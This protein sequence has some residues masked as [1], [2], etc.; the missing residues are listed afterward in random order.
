MEIDT[1]YLKPGMVLVDDVNGK[2]GKP[3]VPKNTTLTDVEIE[4][5]QKFL[6]DKVNILHF[7]EDRKEM[8]QKETSPPERKKHYDMVAKSPEESDPF[9]NVFNEVVGQFKSL[10]NAWKANIPVNM[11]HVR[12]LCLPLF[13][14]V[15]E[16][17]LTDVKSIL[18]G[19]DEDLF[20]YKCVAVSLLSIKLAQQLRYEKKDWLQIGFAAILIDIGLTKSKPVV[21]SEHA[22]PRHPI[23]SYEMIKD[24]PTLTKHTKI[25][26]V[27]HHEHLDGSGFPMKLTEGKIHPFARIIAVAD[28]YFTLFIEE[29]E[30]INTI[31]LSATDKYDEKIVRLLIEK[32][33]K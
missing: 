24:E 32:N 19:R 5:I 6:I 31:L 33:I 22:D 8:K 25:A 20:H 28:R 10:Y 11:F 17:T 30:K 15:K 18:A 29:G 23:I 1:K 21:N 4:F 26:I 2:S 13:E 16:K 9:L 12:Q 27:Q 7:R 14:I 3:I